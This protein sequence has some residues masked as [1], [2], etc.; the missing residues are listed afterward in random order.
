MSSLDS[1]LFLHRAL[2]GLGVVTAIGFC[3]Y[4][5]E[6]E[7]GFIERRQKEGKD[8]VYTEFSLWLLLAELKHY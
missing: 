5:R 6:K 4:M 1:Q 2:K 7:S 3:L 8:L